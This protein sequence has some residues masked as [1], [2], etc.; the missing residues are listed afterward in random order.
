[1]K[2]DILGRVTDWAYYSM[3]DMTFLHVELIT[4][5]SAQELQLL[6]QNLSSEIQGGIARHL[7][8]GEGELLSVKSNML[9]SSLSHV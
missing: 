1:V 8:L 3:S 9:F 6:M 5:Y 2:C 4:G 7:D